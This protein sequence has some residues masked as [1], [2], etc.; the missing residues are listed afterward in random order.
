MVRLLQGVTLGYRWLQRITLGYRLL[1]LM[2]LL[3]SEIS[4]ELL[5]G[6]ERLGEVFVVHLLIKHRDLF[7][8]Q[9]IGAENVK[10]STLFSQFNTTLRT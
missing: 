3:N 8:T 1:T 9:Q 4:V 10:S 7:F 2:N 5:Q 6:N